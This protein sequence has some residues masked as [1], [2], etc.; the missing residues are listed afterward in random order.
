MA[1]LEDLPLEDRVAYLEERLDQTSGRLHAAL[2][3]L[4]RT[5]YVTLMSA[6]AETLDRIRDQVVG[7]C[8]PAASQLYR[9]AM[10]SVASYLLRR[11][12]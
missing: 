5:A 1:S 6:D 10:E 8:P 7:T 11:R 12:R 4:D 3:I 2:E 9:D